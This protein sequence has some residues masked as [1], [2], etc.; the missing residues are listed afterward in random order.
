MNTQ[1]LL[2]PRLIVTNALILFLLAAAPVH[3]SYGDGSPRLTKL[4]QSFISPCCW[5]ENLSLHESPIADQLR[6]RI[7]TMVRDGSPDDAI[8][9]ALVNEF[10]KRILSLPEGPA[11]I[12]LF[13]TPALL[14]VVGAA[15]LVWMLRRIRQTP[16]QPA[17]DGVPAEL[18]L[19]W[20][21][22]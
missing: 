2:R 21:E 6:A 17:F 22:D 4:Y 13:W 14:L 1:S 11:R 10:G 5:R 15:G 3:A 12:W 8:K 7:A 16:A 19:D 18:I 20:D 9:Q